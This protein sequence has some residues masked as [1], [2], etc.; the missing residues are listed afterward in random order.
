MHLA[1]LLQKHL[2][3][4]HQ[5]RSVLPS[6]QMHSAVLRQMRSALLSL[7]THLAALP[8]TRSALLPLQMHLAD[9]RQMRSDLLSLQ[10]HLVAQYQTHSVLLSL[11]MHLAAPHQMCSVPQ[12]RSVSQMHRSPFGQRRSAPTVSFAGSCLSVPAGA[13]R[14]YC[15][16]SAGRLHPPVRYAAALAAGTP[17]LVQAPAPGMPS[18]APHLGSHRAQ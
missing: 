7:Q 15:L 10:M 8:Q 12:T 4:S 9:L 1:A 14:G 16:L 3:V 2:A 6:L 5:T 11:Q 17:R 13:Q 18:L